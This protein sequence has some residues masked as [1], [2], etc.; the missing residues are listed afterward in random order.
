MRGLELEVARK[1]G[2]LKAEEVSNTLCAPA[3]MGRPLAADLQAR[4]EQRGDAQAG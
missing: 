2:D 1:L 3:S 4:L